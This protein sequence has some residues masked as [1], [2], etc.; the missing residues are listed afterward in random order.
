M[1]II[2]VLTYPVYHGI[3]DLSEWLRWDNR[4]RRMP[5]LLAAQGVDV[6]LWGVGHEQLDL[7]SDLPDRPAY[8]I[9]IFP[10]SGGGAKTR[11]HVSDAMAAAARDDTADLFVLIGT[12]G[13]AGYHFHDSALKPDRRRY[14]IIIGGDYWSRIVPGADFVFTES[15]AQE[16]ALGHPGWRIWRRRIAAERMQRLP[17]TIDIDR[18]AP[19]PGATKRWDVIAVSR[20]TRWK[21]FDEIGRLSASHRVAVVGGGPQAAMLARRFPR[22]EWLGHRPHDSVP[23]LLHQARLYFHA[24]RRDYFPRAI[25]E[26]MACGVPVVAMDDRIGPDVVPPSCG[27]LVDDHSYEP[28]VARLLDDTA[29]L[30]AMA[31]AARA[32]VVARHGPQ[33]SEAACARLMEL[34]R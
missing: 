11:D 34:A 8:P 5:G 19:A 26:A 23:A 16:A 15:A 27:A 14:A 12:N 2:F 22:V 7:I 31:K 3:A 25:P 6:E 30:G 9:R 20:L 28:L 4:D 13:G 1:R 18:F 10:M 21:R 24:G 29:R 32:H 17:K 33:S